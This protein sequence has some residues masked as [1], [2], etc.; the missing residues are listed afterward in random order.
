MKKIRSKQPAAQSG[1]S[2]SPGPTNTSRPSSQNC[3]A[4]YQKPNKKKNIKKKSEES[5]L[6]TV[7][8]F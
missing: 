8:I 3:N 7:A 1:E 5:N 2:S 6:L 4:L